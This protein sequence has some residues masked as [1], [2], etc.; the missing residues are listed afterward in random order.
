VAD[1]V[2]FEDV[3]AD[4]RLIHVFGSPFD[5]APGVFKSQRLGCVGADVW[6]AVKYS[7]VHFTSAL[8]NSDDFE[9]YRILQGIPRWPNELSG[10]VFPQEAGIEARAMS[11]TKGCY[12]G[13]EILS[14]IK[15]T[16]KMPRELVRWTAREQ[17]GQHAIAAGDELFLEGKAIG[18]V[19]SVTLH[20]GSGRLTGLAFMKQGAVRM[21]SILLAGKGAPSIEA[22][23]DI[24]AFVN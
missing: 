22:S 21:D 13:Q 24:S 17:A 4:Y 5:P 1:D 11:F 6:S 18:R 7:D 10:D 8:L 23:V 19:T 9:A 14:R 20:P 3:S 12:I 15:S 2:V 16:G